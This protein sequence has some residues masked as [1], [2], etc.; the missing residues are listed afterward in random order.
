MLKLLLENSTSRI[1]EKFEELRARR[2][3]ALV[4]Y[5]TG[6]DPTPESFLKNLEALVAGGADII[7]IGIPFSDPIAD[8]PVIQV[9]SQRSLNAGSTPNQIL[10]LAGRFSSDHPSVPLVLLTYY[11]P[12]LA[13]GVDRFMKRSKASGVSGV[14]VP[15]L[16]VEESGDYRDIASGRGIDTIFLTAPNS[17]DSRL[18][19]IVK[20]S[21]GFIYLVSPYGVTGPRGT[22]SESAIASVKRVKNISDQL[23]AAAG[24]GISKP[25][26]V[27]RLIG[28]GADGAIVGSALVR[29]VNENFSDP[30]NMSELLRL[31]TASLKRATRHEI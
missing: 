12:V 28:S 7:E 17:S 24:F 30:E 5:L 2:E 26:H 8:G 16:P 1:T 11:N 9:S 19:R 3:G 6:G 21:R 29:I 25:N 23:P 10:K 13:M 20:S 15:D 4:A 18:D 14:V 31:K 22:L 27:S